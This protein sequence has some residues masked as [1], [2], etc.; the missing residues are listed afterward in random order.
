[1]AAD[2]PWRQVQLG[3]W[4]LLDASAA[5]ATLL[6]A[7]PGN[8]ILF[9]DGGQ[10][11]QKREY[12][13]G[14]F[15]QVKITP[16]AITEDKTKLSA[17]SSTAEVFINWDIEVTTGSQK[18]EQIFEIQFEILRALKPW[19]TYFDALTWNG[20]RFVYFSE[21][22]GT[23]YLLG[24]HIKNKQIESWSTTWTGQTKTYFTRS[25]L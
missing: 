10:Q 6:G 21:P 2:N 19:K 11:P 8:K 7:R 1:M 17:T 13:E 25:D 5:L 3:I 22:F 16:G 23:K 12:Q 15:P 24:N 18:I 9:L 4:A 14:D 20:K